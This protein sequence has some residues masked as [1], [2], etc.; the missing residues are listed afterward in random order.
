[1]LQLTFLGTSAGKPTKERNVSALA[2]E[3]TQ[4]NKWY[5]FNCGK[6]IQDQIVRSWLYNGK[7][8]R[9]CPDTS[10]LPFPKW[11]LRMNFRVSFLLGIMERCITYEVIPR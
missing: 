5:L 1:M 9:R 6:L 3:F 4:D 2:L 10:T 11:Q 8:R 7:G